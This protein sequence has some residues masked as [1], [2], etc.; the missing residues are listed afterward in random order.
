MQNVI[1]KNL[2]RVLQ[3]M[4]E[5]CRH[6]GRAADA[7]RLVAVTKS[8]TLGQIVELLA[9]GQRDLAENR[10]Q[11]LTSRLAELPAHLDA[12]A[13]AE[14]RWHMIG[15]LQRNKVRD[16]L[17]RVTC[18]HS[19]DSLRLAQSV[20]QEAVRRGQPARVLLQVNA[21]LEPQ[22]CGAGLQEAAALAE[23]MAAL[24]SLQLCG[25]MTMAELSDDPSAVRAA[26]ARARELFEALTPRL[27]PEAFRELS[28]GMSHDFELAIA[29]GATL[30]RVGSA[31]FAPAE[32]P[33]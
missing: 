7:A 5:A 10:V 3:R 2:A 1:A 4:A 8:A 15:H 21:S 14:I 12:Q 28:M 26:F 11:M 22:K 31:L 23:Q 32:V 27:D 30:V 13:M 6:A 25:L 16:V 9:A 20:S 18:I 17:P 29:E 33:Q 19:I 24:P